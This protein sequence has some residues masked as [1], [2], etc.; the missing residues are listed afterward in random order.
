MQEGKCTMIDW[1]TGKWQRQKCH[2][3]FLPTLTCTYYINRF[4]NR[5]NSLSVLLLRDGIILIAT[6]NLWS[7]TAENQTI[8]WQLTMAWNTTTTT[9]VSAVPNAV[10]RRRNTSNLSWCKRY[11][12]NCCLVVQLG[13]PPRDV[14]LVAICWDTHVSPDLTVTKLYACIQECLQCVQK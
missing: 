9:Q 11:N 10:N 2:F 3:S 8:R 14:R 6:K 5:L 13:R 4:G 12:S 1:T 7:N